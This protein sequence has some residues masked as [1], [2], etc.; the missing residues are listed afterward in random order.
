MKIDLTGKYL[1]YRGLDELIVGH[2]Y[3]G[4]DGNSYIFVGF[5]KLKIAYY[6]T[7]AKFLYINQ[8]TMERKINKGILSNDLKVFNIFNE[9]D[10]RFISIFKKCKNP[11]NIK[12][13]LGKIFEE[14][15]FVDFHNK[16]ILHSKN[17]CIRNK[18]VLCELS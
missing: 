11:I 6:D 7:E 10:P 9:N 4:E 3:L 18:I 5:G 14:D 17:R 15:Y 2:A 16:E 1:K 13:D 8:D 12:E